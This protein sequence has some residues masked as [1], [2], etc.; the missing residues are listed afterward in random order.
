M[1][2]E[3]S[4]KMFYEMEEKRKNTE[5]NVTRGVRKRTK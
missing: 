4:D 1:V 5:S 2:T 3:D